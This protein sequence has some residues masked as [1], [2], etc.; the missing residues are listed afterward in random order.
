MFES[1]AVKKIFGPEKEEITEKWK[2]LHEQELHILYA[3]PDII[4]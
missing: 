4:K 1:R 3:S 2:K